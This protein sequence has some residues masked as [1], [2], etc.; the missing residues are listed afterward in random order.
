[1]TTKIEDCTCYKE[2]L[3]IAILLAQ[4][5]KEQRLTVHGIIIGMKLARKNKKE[6]QKN[7]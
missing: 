6:G 2:A 3:E 5:T 1:M 4:L 7:E